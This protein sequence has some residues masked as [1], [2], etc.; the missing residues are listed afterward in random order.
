MWAARDFNAQVWQRDCGAVAHD[1]VALTVPTGALALSACERTMTCGNLSADSSAHHSS[2][3]RQGVTQ[4]GGEQGPEAALAR[5]NTLRIRIQG[6]PSGPS[7]SSGHSDAAASRR[8][9][10]VCHVTAIDPASGAG[11]RSK[12][13]SSRG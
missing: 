1:Q 3:F 5:R 9:Q 6:G 8:G 11:T 2:S 10:H 12:W 13:S 4:P 7:A